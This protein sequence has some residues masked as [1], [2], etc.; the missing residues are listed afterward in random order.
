MANKRSLKQ[1]A[2]VSSS[3]LTIA[4]GCVLTITA[5][6][7]IVLGLLFLASA[8]FN[9]YLAWSLSGYEVRVGQPTSSPTALALVA[10]TGVLAIIP[11]PTA[12][13]TSL[14]LPIA[15]VAPT[16]ASMPTIE[17]SSTA[18]QTELTMATQ[19]GGTEQGGAG[20]EEGDSSAGSPMAE[21]DTSQT[22]VRP[23]PEAI[24]YVV[25][26]GDTLWIIADRAYGAGPMWE[27]IFEE[28]RDTLEDP[29][30]I[31]PGQVLR[32]PLNP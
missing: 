18:A 4:G 16:S 22:S 31:Q 20:T 8:A 32:I 9:V 28:N 21:A 11:T 5:I 25:Q 24:N 23:T 17:T 10:P 29:N 13:P 2:K 1:G 12:A 26:E 30:Q 27:V 3:W 6:C 19:A 14:I 7:S 15:T